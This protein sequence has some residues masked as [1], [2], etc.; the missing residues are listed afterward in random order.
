V[1]VQH[2]KKEMPVTRSRVSRTREASVF[3]TQISQAVGAVQSA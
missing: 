2:G 3:T 1:S